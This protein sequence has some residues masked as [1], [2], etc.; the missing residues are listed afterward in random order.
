M[1]G[2]SLAPVQHR[3]MPD[4]VAEQL[5]SQILAGELSAGR[6]LPGERA[7][8]AALGVSRPTVREALR[9]LQHRG[10]VAIR[11]GG[12]TTVRDFRETAGL[13]LL[14]RL[15]TAGGEL[16]L[17][18]VRD[19]VEARSAIAP[20]MARAAAGRSGSPEEDDAL[21]RAAAA[22]PAA[23]DPLTQQARSLAFWSDVV[24]RS[25]SLVYRLLYNGLRA[26]FEPGMAA[27]AQVL[28][29]EAGH[30]TAAT[31]LARA[32]C[33][34]DPDAAEA[35]ADALLARGRSAVIDLIDH[36]DPPEEPQ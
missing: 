26:A 21:L 30:P 7:L 16:D 20:Q 13:D 2:P 12:A 5:E 24:D 31:D 11:Q 33:V 9:K 1:S 36:L 25:G 8:A 18:L 17:S 29:V 19:I 32:I 14:P 23:E 6:D 4:A 15:L 35:A 10:L 27:L 3:S 22:I 28:A 34:G